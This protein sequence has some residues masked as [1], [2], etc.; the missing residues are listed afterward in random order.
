[1][2]EGTVDQQREQFLA[3]VSHEMRTPLTSIISRSEEHTSE[4]Q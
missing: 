2:A 4:L 3:L 1:M